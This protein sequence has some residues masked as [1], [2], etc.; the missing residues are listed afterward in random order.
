MQVSIKQQDT[1]T[2]ITAADFKVIASY[3]G[4]YEYLTHDCGVQLL[5]YLQSFSGIYLKLISCGTMVNSSNG[6]L[7]GLI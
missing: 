1:F 7:L 2:T 6:T 5:R 4:C 3:C